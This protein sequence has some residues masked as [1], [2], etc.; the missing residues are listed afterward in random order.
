MVLVS[1]RQ[2]RGHREVTHALC[3]QSCVSTSRT[4]V[5][6]AVRCVS[7]VEVHQASG[8]Y[9]FYGALLLR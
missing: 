9:Q 2:R 4:A 5:V 1:I 7:T 6:G 3:H 8:P